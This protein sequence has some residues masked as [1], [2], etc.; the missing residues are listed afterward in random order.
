MN[1]LFV[2]SRNKWRSRTAETIFRENQNFFVRSAGTEPSARIKVTSKLIDWA[3]IIFA[4][5]KK[6]KQRLIQNFPFNASAK[7]IVVLGIPDEYQYMDDELI[8]IIKTS[9]APFLENVI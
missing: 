9:V 2:C 6:H 3:D 8:E 5:E 7:K 4:M 1:V